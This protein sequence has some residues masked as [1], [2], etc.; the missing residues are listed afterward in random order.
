MGKTI[1]SLPIILFMRL[2]AYI[3][4][5]TFHRIKFYGAENVPKKGPVLIVANHVSFYDP[6]IVG[7]GQKRWVRFMTL[8]GYFRVPILRTVIKLCGAFP[9]NPSKVD[10]RTFSEAINILKSGNALGIFPEGG[11]S[12]DGQVH[13]AK[14]GFAVIAV[15]AKATIVPVTIAGAFEAWPKSRMFPRPKKICV[16]FHK[17]MTFDWDECQKRNGNREFYKKV[18]DQVMDKIKDGL[19]TKK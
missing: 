5:K 7:L 18:T 13:E 8:E 2:V 16:R 12:S 15:R 14:P 10:K 11:R 1:K 17:P 6:V 3:Y 4:F 19:N 9:V